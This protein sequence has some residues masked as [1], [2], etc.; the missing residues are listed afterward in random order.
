[1]KNSL[2][3]SIIIFTF[4]SCK[5]EKVNTNLKGGAED[6]FITKECA[7]AIAQHFDIGQLDGGL[8]SNSFD[9]DTFGNVISRTID[10]IYVVTDTNNIAAFYVIS[11]SNNGG[12][13]I[14]SAD[15]RHEPIIAFNTEGNFLRCDNIPIGLALWFDRTIDDI[16]ILRS[17]QY[18]NTSNGI[19]AWYE[20]IHD[21]NLQAAIQGLVPGSLNSPN[22]VVYCPNGYYQKGPL[23]PCTWGQGCT[24]N[25]QL[26]NC[27]SSFNCNKEV[28]GCVATATAQ[29]MKYWG[30]P[31]SLWNF[32]LMPN[33]NGNI[34]VQALM[35]DVG[36]NVNMSYGCNSS[37]ASMS[38][39]K[40]ALK[41]TY[42]YSTAVYQN[43]S[44][45]DMFADIISN[46]P[47]MLDGCMTQ[48]NNRKHWWQFWKAKYVYSN[49]HQW[50]YDGIAYWNNCGQITYD[51]VHLNWGWHEVDPNNLQ[52]TVNDFNGWYSYTNWNIP[53]IGR[54]YQYANDMVGNIHP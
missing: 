43:Y 26:N 32:S 7:V 46:R 29:I 18:D 16:E 33:K 1:M 36:I 27:T 47:G 54:N 11:Y 5:R 42:S 22:A 8:R 6:Y 30:Q 49:C 2:L 50:C 19:Q 45:S 41:N 31:S 9:S 12:W 25:N 13:L 52:P 15:V 48:T 38:D 37:S 20:F 23:L 35:R 44:K 53:G 21:Y 10:S 39:S 40:K 24:Y 28:T 4:F 3:I 17:N 14:L 34:G 51:L